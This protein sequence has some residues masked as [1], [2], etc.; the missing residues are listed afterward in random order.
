MSGIM[1]FLIILVVVVFIAI[2]IY[3]RIVGL[4]QRGDQAFADV[5]VQLKQRRDLIPNLVETVKGY[6][7][8]ERE[9]LDAVISAR[10]TAAS[11][12]GPAEQAQAEGMLSAALG[13]LFA[14]AEAYPDLKYLPGCRCCSK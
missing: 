8:H 7:T 6:A 13:Q 11:A 1:I 10:N 9:T 5:D 12:N 4:N 2:G 14:L 3:N